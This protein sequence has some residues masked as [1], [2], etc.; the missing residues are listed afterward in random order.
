MLYVLAPKGVCGPRLNPYA[1]TFSRLMVYPLIHCIPTVA[2]IPSLLGRPTP[3][4]NTF[5]ADFVS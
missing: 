5:S 3:F 4:V 1:M 2:I